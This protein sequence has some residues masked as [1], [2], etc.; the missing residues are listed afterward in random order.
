MR[1][2]QLVTRLNVGGISTYVLELSQQLAGMGHDVWLVSGTPDPAEGDML[3]Y[4]EGATSAVRTIRLPRLGRSISPLQDAVVL[5]QLFRL[6]R[7][8]RPDVVHTHMSKA[9]TLG[10]L[11]ALG[12]RVPVRIHSMHGTVFEGHF[13][14]LASRI[15]AGA[16][17]A[18]ARL[19]SRILVDSG[20][21]RHELLA[22]RVASD[23]RIEVVPLGFGLLRFR[24]VDDAEALAKP[25][26]DRL[27]AQGGSRVVGMVARLVPVKGIDVFLS[28][29]ERIV[30]GR[31]D[32][33]LILVGDGELRAEIE[34]RVA[35]SRIR[36][37]VVMLGFWPDLR[38]VY[39]ACDVVVLSSWSEGTPVAVI[40][41]MAAGRPVVATRVGGV[42]DLVIDGETG[43]LVAP[44]DAGGLAEGIVRL[45]DD[46]STAARLG[47]AG[48]RRVMDSYTIQASAAATEYVYTRLLS[49][50]RSG[51]AA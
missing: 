11:A 29:A 21:V 26:R 28:A 16:E 6:F 12:A 23:R 27:E 4:Q 9:G 40:E 32:V 19:T 34:R 36:R 51:A 18:L 47:A 22:R 3:S 43:I 48:R 37:S 44:G 8:V 33:K 13:S 30:A 17:R 50:G 1:I 15:F 14:P 46:A 2:V 42:P 45:L 38:E 35:A 49:E 10:R 41:A 31:S 20:G 5:G 25:I 7:S 24:D 39:A